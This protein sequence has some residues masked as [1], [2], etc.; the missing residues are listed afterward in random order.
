MNLSSNAVSGP[1]QPRSAGLFHVVATTSGLDCT[2][3]IVLWCRSPSL[4]IVLDDLA[5]WSTELVGP[6]GLRPHCR[7]N[8][9]QIGHCPTPPPIQGWSPTVDDS[10]RGGWPR[11]LSSQGRQSSVPNSCATCTIEWCSGSAAP[12]D[13]GFGPTPNSFSECSTAW[14]ILGPRGLRDSSVWTVTR[15]CSG[16]CPASPPTTGGSDPICWT[17][18]P[19]R[20]ASSTTSRLGSRLPT[21]V[22]ST[23]TSSL[24]TSWSTV[25]AWA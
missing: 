9:E 21:S 7:N 5:D 20:S 14:R 1:A 3:R 22:W 16:G 17:N 25:A 23:T 4:A 8:V 24:A 2:A 6:W 19:E 15:R 13:G 10:E 18:W 12:D 11:W